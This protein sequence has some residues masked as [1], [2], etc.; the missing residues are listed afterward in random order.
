MSIQLDN[1]STALAS[2]TSINTLIQSVNVTPEMVSR[3]GSERSA[4]FGTIC[5]NLN[6]NDIDSVYTKCRL[7]SA[8]KEGYKE[9]RNRVYKNITELAE[10]CG[11]SRA[12]FGNYSKVGKVFFSG[13]T[14]VQGWVDKH[15]N[16]SA[17]FEL[18]VLTPKILYQ[19]DALLSID[20]TKRLSTTQCREV[21]NAWN[22]GVHKDENAFLNTF[23][24]KS[25]ETV[26]D[27]NGEHE[28]HVYYSPE[29]FI[30]RICNWKEYV[31]ASNPNT[32]NSNDNAN[33]NSND[34]ST[35][36][37][38]SGYS[39]YTVI[40]KG[41]VTEGRLYPD[42]VESEILNY[43][44]ANKYTVISTEHTPKQIIRTLMH[45]REDGV[46]DDILIVTV[47][48]YTAT[49]MTA[50]LSKYNDKIRADMESK[51]VVEYFRPYTA[52][53]YVDATNSDTY[54]DILNIIESAN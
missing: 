26:A 53:E 7:Y 5:A 14:A 52:A 10:N 36:S 54:A 23:V 29:D 8:W 25:I 40:R 39:F 37:E 2:N 19:V 44:A 4:R 47:S 6:A 30:A 35:K 51:G 34:N 21:K 32:D 38:K 13:E 50:V 49:D 43:I 3:F 18:S 15:Y 41:N 20:T 28:Q 33:D 45:V 27:E 9:E 48:P 1:T 31:T 16:A 17:L 12:N 42:G 24:Y 46:P 11:E 22:N